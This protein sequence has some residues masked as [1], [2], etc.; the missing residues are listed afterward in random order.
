[1]NRRP[2][3]VIAGWLGTAVVATVAGVALIGL[4]GESLSGPSG[5][6]LSSGQVHQALARAATTAIPRSTP[7]VPSGGPST[8][9]GTAAPGRPRATRLIT[10]PGG[11]VV[12][13]CSGDQVTLRSW[14]PA[15][16]YEVDDVAPGPDDDA[17][18]KFES[19]GAESEIEVRCSPTGPVYALRNDH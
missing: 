8:T 6:V 18:V 9:G 10:S 12:A 15:Q 3:L 7:A 1:M 17:K 14:S 19:G 4:L 11:S 5:N 2:L 13:S 16:G